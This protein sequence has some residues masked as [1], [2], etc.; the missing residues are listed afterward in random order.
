[1]ERLLSS[2]MTFF[3]KRIFPPMWISAFCFLTL[4]VWIG[5]CRTDSSLKWLTLI[6]LTGGSLFLFWFS[7]RIKDVRLQGDHLVISDY[8]SEELIPLSQVEAVE[9]TRIWNPKLIKLRLVRSGQ[10]G[11]EIIFI[12]PIRFQFVFSDHPLVKE[13]WD[14]IRNKQRGSG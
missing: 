1:M 4:F 8:R 9:E 10:W 13:L 7:A 12:A 3:Y 11:N 6:C 5:A 14:M 2:R